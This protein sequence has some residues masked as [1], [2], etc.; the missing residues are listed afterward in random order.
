MT[1]KSLPKPSPYS[2]TDGAEALA[3]HTFEILLDHNS[4]RTD[5]KN[6]DKFPNTDGYLEMV[7]D[8]RSPVG[9]L[10]VQ[11]RKMT[12]QET[13]I[14]FPLSLLSYAETTCNPV[15]F[16]GVDTDLKK[17]YWIH[18]TEDIVKGKT[19]RAEQQTLI[20]S[21]PSENI[22][23]KD[24]NQYVTSWKKIVKNYQARMKGYPQLEKLYKELSQKSNVL[25]GEELPDFSEI[26][27][28]LDE[29]NTLFDTDFSAI[30]QIFYPNAWKIGVAYSSYEDSSL[31]YTLYP[32]SIQQNDV[33]IKVLDDELRKKLS[34]E[35]LRFFG[36]SAENPIKS[37]TREYAFEIVESDTLR[38]LEHKLLPLKNGFLAIEFVFA[39][40]DKFATQMG[41][42]KNNEYALTDIKKASHDYLPLWVDEAIKFMVSVKRNG[43][44]SP[45]FL[46]YGRPYYDPDILLHQIM[47]KER[48]Q[49]HNQVLKRLNE[50]DNRITFWLGNDKLSFRTFDESL[51]TLE[52]KLSQQIERPYSPKD[53]SRLKTSGWVYN[54]LSPEILEKNL[55][56]FF[57][58]LPSAYSDFVS[59]NFPQIENEIQ[60]FNGSS[61]LI[62][63]F[64]AKENYFQLKDSPSIEL[65][66][67]KNKSEKALQTNLYKKG[68]DEV[69]SGL[70]F[71]NFRKEV[72]IE[73][74]QY[75]M[76]YARKSVLDFIYEELPMLGF[77]YDELEQNLKLYFKSLR[78]G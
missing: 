73:D 5:I 29:I 4:I 35:G 47:G 18:V 28:F 60:L 42:D 27:L 6:R 57:D 74:E 17:A 77:V 38:A 75:Q 25:I 31:A 68:R 48:E 54:L 71:E 2:R 14:Q 78:N 19:L 40:I 55:R 50:G 24:S 44:I 70:S 76:V 32:I 37:R 23:S 16:I 69:P 61:L 11:I 52:T 15:L 13:K 66:G 43:A 30:K 39:F 7:D 9:K 8:K 33:Q 59:N 20:I 64:D 10:E 67:F 45:Y 1:E 72:R 62:V 21:F 12:S 56:I 41:L 22:I 36:Y 34:K 63:V 51:R 58:N 49:I 3:V 53:Y 26:H 46:L 65:Y